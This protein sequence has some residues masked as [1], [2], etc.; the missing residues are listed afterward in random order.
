MIRKP[1]FKRDCFNGG[2]VVEE[3]DW[4]QVWIQQGLGEIYSQGRWGQLVENY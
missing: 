3:R 1:L 2:F 4:V